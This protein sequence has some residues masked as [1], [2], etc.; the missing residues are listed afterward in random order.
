MSEAQAALIWCPFP[1]RDAAREAAA[2]LL[3][4]KLIA[5]ANILPTIESIF[6]YEG[7]CESETECAA[8]FK[9]TDQRTEEAIAML[10][11]LHPYDTPAILSWT[12]DEA[13]PATLDWLVRTT[14]AR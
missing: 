12:C 5:C 9:T 11:K 6:E 13:H 2:R 10:G 14:G 4:E 8:I 3:D 7:R 1:D